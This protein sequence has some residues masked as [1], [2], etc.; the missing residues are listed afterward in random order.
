[1][2]QVVAMRRLDR[3]LGVVLLLLYPLWAAA[4]GQDI[5][6]DA[7]NY[8]LYAALAFLG[9][10]YGQ[11]LLPGGVQTFLNPLASLPAAF[12]L[13]ASGWLGPLLPT[14]ALALLQG[15]TLLLIYWIALRLL[16]GD[17]PLAFLA[18]LFGGTAPL[19]LSEAGNTMADLTLSLLTSASLAVAISLSG[20]PAGRGR[21]LRL[22]LAAGLAGAAVGI[23]ITNLF[24]LPLLAL[25]LA[26]APRGPRE[27]GRRLRQMA[28]EGAVS[29][30]ALLLSLVL[31]ISPQILTAHRYTGNPV[32][33]LLNSVFRSPLHE[34]VNATDWRFKPDS[35]TAFLLAPVFDFSDSFYP[36]FSPERGI[37]TRRCEIRYRDLRTL[38]WVAASLLLLLLPGWRRR[39]TPTVWALLLGLP[40]SYG[41]WLAS[42][43]I[44]RYAIPLQLLFGLPVALACQAIAADRPTASAPWRRPAPILAVLLALTL[45]S[46]VT[47]NWGRTN[48]EAHWTT[49]NG[50]SEYAVVPLRRGRLQFQPGQPIVMLARPLGWFKAHTAASGSRLLHWDPG[51]SARTM[52]NSKLPQVQDR[53]VS[54]VLASGFDTFFLLTFD[55]PPDQLLQQRQTF[56][57]EAP[58]LRA[59]GF[60]LGA[61]TTYQTPE[62]VEDLQLCQVSRRALPNGSPPAAAAASP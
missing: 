56:L 21:L 18:T 57:Q 19:V 43:G 35:P 61:C 22:A 30:S 41:L 38:L 45:L 9:N 51:I 8:H 59:A 50:A 44:G 15:T 31:F 49:L 17:R 36:D 16:Q 4:H 37:Q 48:F 3:R 2:R 6:Y 58:R 53:I 24:F 27:Q 13:S 28:A 62:N 42:A 5:N 14:L 12:L 47:P 60:R 32:F 40:L 52:A 25:A 26:L 1:M 46:Q 7:R 23:K 39:L 20:L 29:L 54:Q 10:S 11:D 33:P 55:G 34:D